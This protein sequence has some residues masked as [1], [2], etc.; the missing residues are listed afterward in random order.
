MK[1]STTQEF[2]RPIRL[3]LRL[4]GLAILTTSC[5][6]TV[7]WTPPPWTPPP[8]TTWSPIVGTFPVRCE[9]DAV[10]WPSDPAGNRGA[11]RGFFYMETKMR[12]RQ[13]AP[14]QFRMIIWEGA[15]A[16]TVL[17]EERG[18]P[19][20][21]TGS[22]SVQTFQIGEIAPPSSGGTWTTSSG[23]SRFNAGTLSLVWQ[24][25]EVNTGTFERF[26]QNTEVIFEFRCTGFP[27]GH[28]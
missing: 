7:E 16:A 23:E 3:L 27:P 21:L 22:D 2:R 11:G 8:G 15:R 25:R 28:P 10:A 17:L 12:I 18:H 26:G 9:M 4:I 5:G 24:I 13:L 14:Q 1:P 20:T 19:F 6:Q